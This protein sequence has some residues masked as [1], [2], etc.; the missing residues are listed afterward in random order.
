MDGIEVSA[1]D[2]HRLIGRA[3][4]SAPDP[5]AFRAVRK[6]NQYGELVVER[7]LVDAI[8]VTSVP[9]MRKDLPAIVLFRLTSGSLHASHDHRRFALKAGEC[10]LMISNGQ[11]DFMLEKSESVQARIPLRLFAPHDIADI[12]AA[13]DTPASPSLITSS[14]WAAVGALVDEPEDD[15]PHTAR[16]Q[17]LEHLVASLMTQVAH[18]I[19]EAQ[20]P[21]DARSPLLTAALLY[22]EDN[23]HNADLQVDIIATAVGTSPRTLNREFRRIGTSPIAAL[24]DARLAAV[25]HRLTSKAPLPPLEELAREYGY[26]DRTALTRAFRRRY[27]RSPM[28]HRHRV[29]PH[30]ERPV[31][32]A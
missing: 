25:A 30:A 22:L 1:A 4:G 21:L 17:A 2:I 15:A 29:M 6:R 19:V 7:A 8:R 32:A 10:V 14:V 5:T 27:G 31:P 24:R 26:S 3:R 23:L 20:R 11:Y 16:D 28:E 18:Q 12:L 13:L 9:A